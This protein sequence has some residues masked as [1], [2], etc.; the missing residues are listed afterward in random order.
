MY[1]SEVLPSSVVLSPPR[2]RL[3][4][5]AWTE[6]SGGSGA[7]LAVRRH[8]IEHDDVEVFVVTDKRAL[9][10][11]VPWLQVQ[12]SRI[13]ARLSRTRFRRW[14]SNYEMTLEPY[15]VAARILRA[16][17][18]FCA[19]AVLTV[20]DNSLSWAAYLVAKRSN[21]PFITN[22][23]DWWPRGQFYS[24]T[25][26][27]YRIVQDLLERGYRHDVSGKRPG[28]LHQR[29]HEAISGST[30]YCGPTAVPE[31]CMGL[32]QTSRRRPAGGP[33]G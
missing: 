2:P 30:P 15:F 32:R 26:K 8:L 7:C 1:K 27:P 17:A 13:H 18:E 12:R 9:E 10:P 29:R 6:P 19:D 28:I 23:Q 16:C 22:F 11:G 24:I 21:L 33:C 31:S 4:Y 25:E 20:P 3:L 14:V 5:I